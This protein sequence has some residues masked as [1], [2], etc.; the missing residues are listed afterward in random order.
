[1][2]LIYEFSAS[3]SPA[4]ISK[5]LWQHNIGHRIIHTGEHDQ[6]WLLNP[7]HANDAMALIQQW[8]TSPNVEIKPTAETR[9]K[10]AAK[11]EHFFQDW[12]KTPMTFVFLLISLLVAVITGLGNYLDTVSWFTISSF[13]IIGNQIQFAP[14]SQVLAEG[15]YWR[16]ITPAFLHFGFA[17]IIFNSLWVWEIGRKLERLMGSLAWLIFAIAVCIASNVGQYLI[18]G[19]PLFGGLSGLV[20]GLVAFAWVMPILLK[21]WP[22]IVP[23]PLMIFFTIWLVAG[24]TDIFSVIGLGSIANEAHLLG[25]VSGLAF[26]GMYS[27][28]LKVTKKI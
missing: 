19:Y 22:T 28:I 10:R 13:N 8:Q 5:T 3:E 20:Y 26:A 9:K 7:A 1:M 25:L 21:G 18:N 23:K 16:L 6:L 12:H 24:Y 4:L 14:L 27:L 17:H 11:A 15:E 2:L